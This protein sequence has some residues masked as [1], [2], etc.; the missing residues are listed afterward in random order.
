MYL[1]PLSLTLLLRG[2]DLQGGVQTL[3]NDHPSLHWAVADRRHDVTT[4][5]ISDII[6]WKRAGQESSTTQRSSGIIVCVFS[7]L[8]MN[9]GLYPANPSPLHTHCSASL[10][11]FLTYVINSGPRLARS[12]VSSCSFISSRLY[13]NK[14]EAKSLRTTVTDTRGYTKGAVV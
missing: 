9:P 13:F 11:C 14:P 1:N 6:G 7:A 4:K 12:S 8:Y 3:L 2:S 10:P 5:Y